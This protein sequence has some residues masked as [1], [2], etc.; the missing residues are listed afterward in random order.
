MLSG[1]VAPTIDTMDTC[2]NN[3]CKMPSANKKT[4][5]LQWCRSAVAQRT[6]Q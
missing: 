2:N 3:S 4:G 1:E 6:D 5:H